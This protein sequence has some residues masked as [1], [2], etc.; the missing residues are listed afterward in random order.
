MIGLFQ[1]FEFA[2][3]MRLIFITKS[4]GCLNEVECIITAAVDKF[5]SIGYN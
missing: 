4:D 2:S 3:I 5:R 1:Q